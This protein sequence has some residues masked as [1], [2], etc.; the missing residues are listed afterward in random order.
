M[1]FTYHTCATVSTCA[2]VSGT[3]LQW[4]LN[5]QGLFEHKCKF[6][7]SFVLNINVVISKIILNQIM[8]Y[9]LKRLNCKVGL[10]TYI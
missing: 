2:Q 6:I 3:N 5:F 4:Y 7:V 9:N 1:V 10:S 8:Q